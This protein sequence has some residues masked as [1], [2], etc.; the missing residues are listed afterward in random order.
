MAAITYSKDQGRAL[1]A[2]LMNEA[3]DR[4]AALQ[5][6]IDDREQWR[7]IITQEFCYIQ[8][9]ALCELIAI[10]CVIAHGDVIDTDTM[11]EYK[12]SKIMRR[13]EEVSSNFYPRGVIV[14][15]MPQQLSFVDSDKP[16]LTR[17]ELVELWDTAGG[18]V[19]R[20]SARRVFQSG[21][22]PNVNLDVIINWGMKIKNLLEVHVISSAD[23][24]EHLLV[25]LAHEQ[26]GGGALVNVCGPGPAAQAP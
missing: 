12:P 2:D 5:K 19:H 14:T 22:G 21:V 1:Y 4:L 10:A 23:N 11:K 6:A 8:L 20:G 26:A 7:P 15:F 24:V 3:R 18:F 25:F 16:Q 17:D 9:R 13:L